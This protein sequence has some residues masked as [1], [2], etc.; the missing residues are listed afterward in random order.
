MKCE[1]NGREDNPGLEPTLWRTCRVLTHGKRLEI[2]E[3]LAGTGE[4]SVTRIAKDCGVSL[5]A[6]TQ[7]LRQ[8]Q[9]RGLIRAARRSRWVYYSAAPDPL[10]KHSKGVLEA[11]LQALRRRHTHALIRQDLTAFTHPR[12]LVILRAL[13]DHPAGPF[14]LA[15]RCRISRPAVFRHLDK[16]RRRG[17]VEVV[18]DRYQLAQ[19][20]SPLAR[21]LLKHTVA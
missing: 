5:P 17:V 12:R 13:A 14:D 6:A 3:R 2:L 16:L 18:V 21:A 7:H 9:S 4:A 20:P 19:P 1:S 11:V 15:A 10:V 8:L